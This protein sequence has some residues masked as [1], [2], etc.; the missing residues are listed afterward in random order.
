MK[1]TNI[2][3]CRSC[4]YLPRQ[5]IA[6]NV[7]LLI[8]AHNPQGSATMH[9]DIPDHSIHGPYDDDNSAVHVP[10]VLKANEGI[11]AKFDASC[12]ER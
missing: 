7:A 2:K 10:I 8:I 6:N 3:F 9:D 5:N 12:F 1:K 4:R 11:F